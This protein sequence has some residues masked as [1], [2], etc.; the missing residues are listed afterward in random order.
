[1]PAS[2]CWFAMAAIS[3]GQGIFGS[4][5]P[6]YPARSLGSVASKREDERYAQAD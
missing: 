3:M 5:K 2:N 6:A 1:M 4:P